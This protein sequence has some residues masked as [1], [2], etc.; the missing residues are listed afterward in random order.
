MVYATGSEEKQRKN[1]I[2]RMN[3]LSK[4]YS[5]CLLRNAFMIFLIDMHIL[6]GSV[7]LITKW[8]N[9]YKEQ[10]KASQYSYNIFSNYWSASLYFLYVNC[11]DVPSLLNFNSNCGSLRLSKYSLVIS[12][13][14]S[15]LL[16]YY[17]HLALNVS[18]PK[19]N[20]FSAMNYLCLS[21]SALHFKH[22]R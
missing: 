19:I 17:N 13:Y 11:S 8:K 1:V 16:S 9:S 14:L 3:W 7:L 12:E 15:L 6:Q 22:W 5:G 18:L 4:P 10:L 21:D 2:M 20:L